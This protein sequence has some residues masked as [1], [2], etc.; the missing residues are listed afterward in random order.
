MMHA[1]E[2]G[3]ALLPNI[4]KLVQPLVLHAFARLQVGVP[5]TTQA[6]ESHLVCHDLCQHDR[7]IFIFWLVFQE[8]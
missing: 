6:S 5:C 3:S 1:N 4:G 2:Y 8:Q 7:S